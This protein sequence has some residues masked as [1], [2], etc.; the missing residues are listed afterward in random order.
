MSAYVGSSKNLKDLKGLG[1]G[2]CDE[3]G[4]SGLTQTPQQKR[5]L[6][7]L[8]EPLHW[9]AKRD[10]KAKILSLQSLPRKG[11]SLGYVGRI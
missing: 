3:S 9:K 2:V 8:H 10:P 5:P 1:F 4:L 11:V 7:P 6:S